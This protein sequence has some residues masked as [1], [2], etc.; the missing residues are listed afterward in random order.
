MPIFNEIAKMINAN[1]MPCYLACAGVRCVTI[2]DTRKINL[3]EYQFNVINHVPAFTCTY[4]RAGDLYFTKPHL[5]YDLHRAVT[6][7]DN[8]LNKIIDLIS[9]LMNDAGVLVWL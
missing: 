9:K 1:F 7:T 5:S 2:I 3:I 4:E 6:G 8:D